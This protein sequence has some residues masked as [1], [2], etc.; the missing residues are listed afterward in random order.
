MN[1]SLTTLWRVIK[2]GTQNLIRN[3]TLSIAAVAVM[4]IT[5]TAVLFLFVVNTTFEHTVKGITS[6]IDISVYLQDSVSHAQ[7]NSLIGELE[8]L[9]EVTSV[10]YISKAE[11]LKLYEQQ[12]QGNV[13]LENAIKETNNPLPATI[14][15][16]PVNPSQL[17]QIKGVLNEPS[18]LALQSDPSSYSG[19]LET[20]I[21]KIA[22]TTVVF[23]EIG[24]TGIIVFAI[25][26]ILIIFNTIR[27]TIFNRRDELTIMRLLGAST[28]Y[29]R[30]PYVIES[31]FYGV[32]S[33]LLSILIVNTIFFTISNSFQANSLGLLD[34]NYAT[35]YFKKYFWII[36]IIQIG[37]GILIGA[38]SSVFATRRYL[39]F[40]TS[41]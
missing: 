2:A 30:G 23:R 35:T 39:K 10:Q 8:K 27:M 40:K 19:A 16:K 31:V 12:N 6:K 34:I 4:T 25:V 5:L 9:P 20:S 29:V 37:L 38:A 13:S 21:N 1:H 7:T 15:I 11:A 26:S 17:G 32:I 41:K 33:G 28:W 24:I 3:V 18:V 36:L 22:R 14:I